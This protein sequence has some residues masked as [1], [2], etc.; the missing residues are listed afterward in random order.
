MHYGASVVWH[1]SLLLMSSLN[2]TEAAVFPIQATVHYH[3]LGILVY[4]IPNT[5]AWYSEILLHTLYLWWWYLTVFTCLDLLKILKWCSES[6]THTQATDFNIILIFIWIIK[7]MLQRPQL[8][9]QACYNYN[10]EESYWMLFCYL[11]KNFFFICL[12]T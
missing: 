8:V 1:H 12:K 11:Q 6:L 10:N 2:K 5:Q 7:N 9:T 3:F 4:G